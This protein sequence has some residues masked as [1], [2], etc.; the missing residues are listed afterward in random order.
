MGLRGHRRNHH[1]R[2]RDPRRGD[3]GAAQLTMPSST[4]LMLCAVRVDSG[5]TIV[6]L[7]EQRRRRRWRK[8]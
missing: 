5:G 7:V 6:T 8:Q 1:E 2:T 3:T 4:F